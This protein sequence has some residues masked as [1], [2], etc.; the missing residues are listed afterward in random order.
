MVFTRIEIMSSFA[1]SLISF[2][3]LVG[4]ALLGLF[5]SNILPKHHLS[6]HSKDAIKVGTGLIATLTALVLGLLVSSSKSSFDN[7]N[8]EIKQGSATLILLDHTLRKYGPEA[9]PARQ[10]VQKNIQFTLE[11]IWPTDNGHKVNIQAVEQ[12]PGIEA[13]R[14]KIEELNPKNDKEKG[15]QMEAIQLCGELAHSRWL[16]VEQAKNSLPTPFLVILVFWLAMFFLSF[17]LL[18]P[19]NV[20]VITVI[21]ISALSV[22]GAI[23]LILEMN[24]PLEGMIKISSA[25]LQKALTFIQK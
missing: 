10:L 4:G 20:T 7:M 2:G 13:V 11:K 17:G 19:H 9:M 18:A 14:E 25:P 6:D 22:A 23:F 21:L 1:I 5:L 3:C 15:L 12:S 24:Q 8:E 16:L